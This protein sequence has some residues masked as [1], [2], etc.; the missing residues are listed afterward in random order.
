MLLNRY[1]SSISF[2]LITLIVLVF[3]TSKLNAQHAATKAVSDFR[4][5]VS[6]AVS[7]P[8]VLTLEDIKAMPHDTASLKDHDGKLH[9]YA[10]VNI[11]SIL[12]KAGAVP[13]GAL[14]GKALSR[15][16]IAKCADG[17]RVLFSLAEL[18]GSFTDRRVL[19]ADALEGHPLP[20]AKGP[21]RIVVP[22]EKKGARSC[23]QVM[24]LVVGSIKD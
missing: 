16:M 20:E 12:D 15:Y 24:E 13:D 18:D 14:K 7:Q 2:G 3:G 6:G 4:L 1:R 17:Y 5:K 9:L 19:I 10:G 22:G 11:A 23:F 21:L 8:L